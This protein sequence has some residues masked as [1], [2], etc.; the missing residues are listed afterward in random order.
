MTEKTDITHVPVD[1]RMPACSASYSMPG[2]RTN[3]SN[4]PVRVFADRMYSKTLQINRLF[5]YLFNKHEFLFR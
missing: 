4:Q 1:G 5:D 3:F 2:V